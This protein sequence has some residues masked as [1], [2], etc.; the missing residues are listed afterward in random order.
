MSHAIARCASIAIFIALA[1]TTDPSSAS[2]SLTAQHVTPLVARGGHDLQ[3]HVATESSCIAYCTWISA[4]VHY[5]RQ[6]EELQLALDAPPQP[7]VV[8]SPVIPGDNVIGCCY[9]WG[10][11][12]YWIEVRQ[13]FGGP[14]DWQVVRF[15]SHG[16]YSVVVLG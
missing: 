14:G 12:E 6:G 1:I 9:G 10:S 13:G 5:Y 4:T 16:R 8:F 11:F 7:A 2:H 3:M 15:P